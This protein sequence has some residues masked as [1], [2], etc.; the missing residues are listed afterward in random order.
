MA[1]TKITMS[2][3]PRAESVSGAVLLL[4]ILEDRLVSMEVAQLLPTMPL[5]HVINVL[6]GKH[7]WHITRQKVTVT[8]A[9][10]RHAV[11]MAYK[12]PTSTAAAARS[13]VKSVWLDAAYKHLLRNY[14]W[15]ELAS[16]SP[17][18]IADFA[19]EDA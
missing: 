12:L 16:S 15:C 4:L 1:A 13:I 9:G 14:A 7:G 10:C 17:D 18:P 19:E 2:M 8:V 3:F 5:A 6:E 11:V